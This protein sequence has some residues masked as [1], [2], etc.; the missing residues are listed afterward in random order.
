VFNSTIQIVVQRPDIGGLTCRCF[1]GIP[2]S[3]PA[4]ITV[5][6]AGGQLAEQFADQ[7]AIAIETALQSGVPGAHSVMAPCAPRSR[8]P[9]QC[10]ANSEPNCRRILVLV[11]DGTPS[12]P[13]PYGAI[14]HWASKLS[15]DPNFVVLPCFP[16]TAQSQAANLIPTSF[17]K[18][19]AFFWLRDPSEV[20]VH[21]LGVAG[22]GEEDYR[23]FIS[24]RRGEGQALAEQLFDELNR[25]NFE[26][27]LDQFRINPGWNF[28]E[29]LTEE[30]AHKSMIVV[31]ETAQITQSQWIT[32][33]VTYAVRNRLGILAIQPPNGTSRPEISNRRRLFMVKNSIDIDGTIKQPW[34]DRVCERI[35]ILHFLAI[36]RKR[37]QMEQAMRNALLH[38]GIYSLQTTFDGFLEVADGVPSAGLNE[39]WVTPRPAELADFQKAY[40]KIGSASPGNP[41]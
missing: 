25:R 30:L 9:I 39:L 6:P 32:H 1:G 12:F 14:Q 24:Y 27:F 18:V 31:L 8:G 13:D 33:E 36:V 20:A 19:N 21:A 37:N 16:R 40:A 26:V 5:L 15:V 22:I 2:S 17:T 11:F 34:L 7:A 3:N 10:Q 35:R 23:L 38:E 41:L 29:R 4:L 28:Q